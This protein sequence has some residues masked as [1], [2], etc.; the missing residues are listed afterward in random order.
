[1]VLY[2]YIKIS[3]KA[4]LLVLGFLAKS[5]LT[6]DL[7][8]YIKMSWIALLLILGIHAHNWHI[9]LCIVCSLWACDDSCN[10]HTRLPGWE[11]SQLVCTDTAPVYDVL[12][13]GGRA[14]TCGGGGQRE[15]VLEL[16]AITADQAKWLITKDTQSLLL[17]L[18]VDYGKRWN[19][20]HSL[21]Q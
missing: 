9:V 3:C 12:H 21:E 10:G 15:W 14:Q 11:R 1:M 6:V 13:R 19:L 4:F 2:C 7:N 8:C 20:H 18:L 5:A 17:L 16:W